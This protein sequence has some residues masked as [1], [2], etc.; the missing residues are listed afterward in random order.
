MRTRQQHD[1][2]TQRVLRTSGSRVRLAARGGLLENPLS[3]RA[4]Q[5]P[6][7][8]AVRRTIERACARRNSESAVRAAG[9]SPPSQQC[10]DLDSQVAQRCAGGAAR[11]RHA[12]ERTGFTT[13]EA[14]DFF[15]L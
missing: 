1:A 2:D 7:D 14:A 3:V 11:A 9:G 5:P 12:S 6:V 10:G 8:E 15:A 4:P 13:A